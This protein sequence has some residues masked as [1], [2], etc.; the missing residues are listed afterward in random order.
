MIKS[1][2][3]ASLFDRIDWVKR[4]VLIDFSIC[5]G[6]PVVSGLVSSRYA[7]LLL[8]NDTVLEFCMGVHSSGNLSLEFLM[9]LI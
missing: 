5:S 6:I 3:V 2:E 8:L 1:L 7:F 4:L 9:L